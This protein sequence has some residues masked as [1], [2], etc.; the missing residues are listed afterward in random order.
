M[1]RR[2]LVLGYGTLAYLVFLVTLLATIG[3]LADVGPKGI[4]D[5]ATGPVWAA[6][7]VNLALL[8]LFAVQHSVMA[9]PWF[10]RWWTGV[11]PRS[12]ERSTYVLVA[13]LVVALLLW[14]WRPLPDPVWS[15]SAG[16]ARAALWT[17]YLLG[18]GIL[19]FS[20][21]LIGHFDLFGVR[22]AL[23]EA[24]ERQYAEPEFREPL[25][26]R[27]V[28]HPLMVGFLI[29]FWVVPDMS[30]GRLLFVAVA[31]GYILVAVRF[32]EHDLR[33]QLGEP[34]ERYLAR[35]PRFVPRPSTLVNRRPAA[36]PAV[37]EH[38]GA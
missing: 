26:Y 4:N 21:F 28:R 32:E 16:W 25:L 36:E 27:F 24:R 7:L 14:Q 6:V 2:A 8:S 34:Y 31:T 19:V 23:A 29:A 12:I 37:T 38:T 17:L 9:R 3:F 22:Q 13:S 15:V 35:V 1:V 5:G 11:I 30:V 18:W 10:K 20:S 33:R